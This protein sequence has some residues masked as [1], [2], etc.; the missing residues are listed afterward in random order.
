MFATKEIVVVH[1]FIISAH[2]LNILFTYPKISNTTFSI[3][4]NNF[5]NIY[6]KGINNI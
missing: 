6:L 4:K 3:W 5:D 1:V 2:L